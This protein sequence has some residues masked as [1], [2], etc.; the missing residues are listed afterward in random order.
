MKRPAQLKFD[1]LENREVPAA[2]APGNVVIYRVGTGTGALANDGAPVF[3]DEYSPTGTLVQSV[4]MPT[5]VV[6]SNKQLVADGLNPEEGMLTRATNGESLIVTGYAANLGFGSSLRNSA[7]NAVNRTIGVVS[8]FGAIDTRTAL[9]NFADNN[10]IHSAASTNGATLW[11]VGGGSGPHVANIAGTSGTQLNNTMLDLQ[12][13]LISNAQLYVSSSINPNIGVGTL[14]NGTP[15]TAGQTFTQLSGVP[16]S[17]SPN[18]FFFADINASVPGDDVLYIADDGANA[19]RKY[20]LVGG[21]WVLNGTIGGDADDYRGLTGSVSGTIVSLYATRKGGTTGTGGGEFVSFDDT[22]GYNGTFSGSPTLRA[23]AANNTAFRGIAMSPVKVNTAPVNSLAATYNGFEDQNFYLTGL[24]ITDPDASTGN[25]QV[26]FGVNVGAIH[27]NTAVSGGVSAGQVTTNGTA[28]VVLTAPLSAILTTFASATGVRFALNANQSGSATL[29]MTTSDQGNTGTDGVKTDNDTATL[30]V[31][32]VNDAPTFAAGGEQFVDEDSGLKTVTNWA[33]TISAGPADESG[34]TLT[35]IL[36]TDNDALFDV[37][38]QVSANGTLTFTPALH[39]NGEANVTIRLMDDGGN[40]NGGDDT[41]NDQT[42]K[43]TV[44]PA[45][46]PPTFNIAG[47]QTINEDAGAQTVNSFVSNIVFGPTDEVADLLLAA[48]M[49]NNNNSLFAVQPF[50]DVNT[51]QLKYTPAANAFGMATVSIQLQDNGGTDN[52]GTDLSPVQ[53]FTIT[54]NPVNDIPSFTKGADQTVN[55][56][57]G[58]QTIPGWATGISVGP[59]NENAQTPSFVIS[60]SNDA[61]FSTLPAVSANGTLTYEP[62]LNANG[63]AVVT[64]QVQDTGGTTNGGV[65]TSASQTFNITV[66]AKNDAPGFTK[67]ADQNI[68]EDPGAQTITGWATSINNGGPDE[69]GQILTFETSNDNNALF[70]VQ[71]T[72]SANGTLT[73]TPTANAFGT[74]VVT[75]RLKDNGGTANG[76]ADTS[77]DQTF[78]ITVNSVND[79]PAMS[80]QLFYLPPSATVGTSLGTIIATDVEGHGITYSIDPLSDPDGNFS[81][82]ASTGEVQ[83]ASLTGLDPVNTIT[84]LATDNGSPNAVGSAT[85]DIRLNTAPV[86]DTSGTPMLAAIPV[87]GKVLPAG[88]LISLLTPYVS[89]VDPG[90]L[91]GI[92]IVGRDN[93]K[94]IWEYNLTGNVNGWVAV[95]AVAPNA[96][97]LLADDGNTLL[98]FVPNAKFTGFAS[99]SFKAWDRTNSQAEGAQHDTTGTDSSYSTATDLGWIAVGKTNPAVNAEG[100]VTPKVVKEDAKL[101]S[102][103]T[104]KNLLG[105]AGLESAPKINLGIALTDATTATG[106]WQYKLTGT[107]VWVNVPAVSATV[108][109]LLKPTD[110]LRFA[111]LANADTTGELTFKT[112]DQSTGTFGTTVDPVGAAYGADPGRV[113]VDITAINDAPV[114]DLTKAA[115]LNPVAPAATSNSATFAALMSVIDVEN[116]L[117]SVVSGVAVTKLTGEGTWQYRPSA[118]NWTPFPIVSTKKALLLDADTEVRFIA[119]VIVSKPGS[120]TLSFKA[121]DKSTGTTGTAVPIKGTAFSTGIEIVSLAVGNGSPILA[122]GNPVLAN[123]KTA[124]KPGSGTLVKTLLGTSQTDPD[125]KGLKGIAITNVD[126]TNGQWQYSLGSNK[127]VNITAASLSAAILLKDTNRLRFVPNT[128]F[129]GTATISFKA[130]D[131]SAGQA[132]DSGVD[133]TGALNSFSAFEETAQITVTL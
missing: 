61:L 33:S 104:V 65:D 41:S 16:T 48:P 86:L 125:L 78:N 69:A 128:G 13:V 91:E 95:P 22:T 38:P 5:T 81:I 92:A 111:P 28:N 64:I 37:L 117:N 2:F 127:W 39:R 53:N 14:G 105:I 77:A 56:D 18:S 1:T 114:L 102:V 96:A 40:L 59:L 63:S 94:G 42:F 98:R 100:A 9:D 87:R 130:W 25:I 36:T 108:A 123:I 27:I 119:S 58:L 20:S 34:Q 109:L 126:N 115:I 49:T 55:E 73:Y 6:G 80:N 66:N 83:L 30:I 3:L 85:V 133:T 74:A 26:T 89:D 29:T 46:D 88:S 107:K 131:Q 113:V 24:S 90:S 67:G 82:N 50:L 99:L 51:L 97:L 110:Q 17:G 52:T 62:A 106:T 12:T 31:D 57:P 70:S 124:A 93:A 132:G 79:A 120:A 19:L 129:T 7:A 43:I 10:A 4:A 35:F 47:N 60:T 68:N 11:A 75:I 32:P 112:W 84:V 122:N 23:I 54:I 121:W 21:T 15:T 101:S 116:D 72:V 44:N 45:N 71:P 118:G 8:A 76:G 103:Y